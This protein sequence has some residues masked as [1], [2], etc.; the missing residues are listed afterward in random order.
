MYAIKE[1]CSIICLDISMKRAGFKSIFSKTADSIGIDNI[2]ESVRNLSSVF[3]DY[4]TS[5]L[6]SLVE[7]GAIGEKSDKGF[8]K[9]SNFSSFLNTHV[10]LESKEF[11]ESRKRIKPYKS[12][13]AFNYT[14]VD[15]ILLRMAM[16]TIKCL[17]E[18]LV[19]SVEA[20]DIAA[21][22]GAGFP[23]ELGGPLVYI[24]K[25]KTYKI[26]KKM[27]KIYKSTKRDCFLPPKYLQE[28][29]L[30][31]REFFNY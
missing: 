16:E 22:H 2:L 13:L 23:E 8:L 30:E 24:D 19:S 4:D 14:Y 31:H 26:Y 20:A 6:E 15:R 12:L 25:M 18:G 29:R 17:D 7:K 5:I 1:G 9:H 27:Q 3:P 11:K 21:V 10:S 28:W